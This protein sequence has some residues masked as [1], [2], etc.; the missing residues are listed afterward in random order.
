MSWSGVSAL[1]GPLATL[2]V[3]LNA[4]DVIAGKRLD[5]LMRQLAAMRFADPCV[6]LG[7]KLARKHP[8]DIAAISRRGGL[9]EAL[10]ELAE[11]AGRV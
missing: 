4:Q 6:E 11:T 8:S 2:R 5:R 10:R 1:G 9:A 7:R 3:S